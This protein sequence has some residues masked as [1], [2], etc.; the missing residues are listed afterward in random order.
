MIADSHVTLGVPSRVNVA[1]TLSYCVCVSPG[2]TSRITR[3]ISTHWWDL[4]MVAVVLGEN[5]YAG[6][7]FRTIP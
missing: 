5:K 4:S 2:R 1:T 6:N 7:V 3:L